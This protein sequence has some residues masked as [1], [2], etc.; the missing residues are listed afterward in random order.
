MISYKLQANGAY[1]YHAEHPKTHH[2]VVVKVASIAQDGQQE[3]LIVQKLSNASFVPRFIDYFVSGGESFLFMEYIAGVE[4]SP[5][6]K[7][8]LVPFATQLFKVLY[9]FH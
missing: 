7:L 9:S 3:H 5:S 8:E 4:P 2:E 6:F 1:V